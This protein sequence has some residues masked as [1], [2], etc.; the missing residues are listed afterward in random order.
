MRVIWWRIAR[1]ETASGPIELT[2]ASLNIHLPDD[3][4]PVDLL[5]N[6]ED[7]DRE[8]LSRLL[9]WSDGGR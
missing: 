2:G 1:P 4:S 5:K 9:E 7:L 3:Q 6:G 8:W